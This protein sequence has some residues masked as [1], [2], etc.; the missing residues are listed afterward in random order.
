LAEERFIEE[1]A[2]GRRVCCCICPVVGHRD[3]CARFIE[4]GEVIVLERVG[5]H[6]SARCVP[7]AQALGYKPM[8][9]R[10]SA[11]KP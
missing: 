7:C 8:T 11:I 1:T 3:V 5:E 2:D 9:V 4:A 6:Y 10:T